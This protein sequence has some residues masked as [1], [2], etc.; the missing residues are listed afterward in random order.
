MEGRASPVQ[1]AALLV[2]LR[3]RGAVAGGGGGRRAGAARRDGRRCPRRTGGS[4]STPAA[5]A[6]ERSPP[7]TSPP[8]PRWSPPAPVC[9]RQARE[10]QL[11]LPL[12]QRRRAR[13]ARRAL[14]LSPEQEARVSRRPG[15]SSCSLPLHHPAMR[16]VAPI[17]RELAM[18]TIMNVLGPLTNP[19]GA[20]GRWSA[21]RIP[22]L[23]ELIA[24]RA[25]V[26]G[27]E[28]ALV[29]HGEP[30]STS[31]AR[32]A[33]R[34]SWSC[35]TAPIRA[36]ELRSRAPSSAG[37]RSSR[38]AR[39]RR[40][41]ENA[42][43]SPGVLKGEPRRRARGGRCSTR[44]RAL[45]G[46]RAERCVE[47]CAVAEARSTGAGWDRLEALRAASARAELPDQ[48]AAQFTKTA[49][50]SH[51]P[52]NGAGAGFRTKTSRRSPLRSGPPRRVRA[53]RSSSGSPVG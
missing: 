27:H 52:G 34:R 7:S 17:R 45:R 43:W 14:D 39:G 18:P 15:S 25:R 3:V 51:G 48:R 9:G 6:G 26:L 38:G 5:P 24:E 32:S 12:R 22:K 19:A 31:S 23:L 1:M 4:W 41:A 46:R 35:A 47:G 50:S 11:H 13:G 29:V 30:G 21:S 2:A 20:R 36:L 49:R 33:P 28:R 8:P 16:H 37:P 42:R 44:P 10:P 53:C 40:P